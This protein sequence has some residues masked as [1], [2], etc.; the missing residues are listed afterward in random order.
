MLEGIT[1]EDFDLVAKHA[2][3]LGAMSQEA[4]WRAFDDREY[5]RYSDTF[6]R[7]AEDLAKAASNHNLDG[8]TLAYVKVTMSCVECHKFVRGRKVASLERSSLFPH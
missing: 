6:R 2:R 5:V 4:S 7:H 8:M 1:L 3:R